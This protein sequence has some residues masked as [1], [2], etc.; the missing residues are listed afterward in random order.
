[1]HKLGFSGH[2]LELRKHGL[3]YKEEILDLKN[4][5]Q[6]FNSDDETFKI[7]IEIVGDKLGLYGTYVFVHSNCI[8]DILKTINKY[9]LNINNLVDYI[10]LF[11]NAEQLVLTTIIN[12][13]NSVEAYITIQ[14]SHGKEYLDI[15]R[16]LAMSKQSVIRA[17]QRAQLCLRDR[18]RK[19]LIKKLLELHIIIEGAKKEIGNYTRRKAN[20]PKSESIYIYDMSGELKKALKLNGITEIGKI[21]EW[22]KI[23]EGSSEKEFMIRHVYGMRMNVYEELKGIVNEMYANRENEKLE[24][25]NRKNEI[26]SRLITERIKEHRQQQIKE[27]WR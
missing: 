7:A 26:I 1:M 21:E 19:Q 27:G 8:K 10:E 11:V 17:E 3:E 15:A 22:I 13:M 25:N 18:G 6:Y 20:K 16:E 5:C 2:E 24:I 9:G 12:S 14:V 4:S 23:V